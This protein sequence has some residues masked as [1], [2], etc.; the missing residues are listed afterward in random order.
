M[1]ST[2]T[3]LLLAPIERLRQLD[4]VVFHTKHFK[5]QDH[6]CIVNVATDLQKYRVNMC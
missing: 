4:G 3:L 5:Q 6:P 2:E 1:K